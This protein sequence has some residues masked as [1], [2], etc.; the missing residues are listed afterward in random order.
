MAATP[1]KPPEMIQM[2]IDWE[3]AGELPPVMA[4]NV[5]LIQQTPH[6]FILTFGFATPPIWLG[7]PTSDQIEKARTI[8]PCPIVR[9]GMSPGRMVELL[10]VVQ[11]QLANYQQ[12][13]KH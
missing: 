5:F 12:S 1:P 8:K 7:P 10:Q 6:E 13:Q 2:S 4:S 11:Q 3:Q 9:L